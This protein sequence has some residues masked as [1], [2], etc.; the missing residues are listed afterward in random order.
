MYAGTDSGVAAPSAPSL[1]V[2]SCY[3]LPPARWRPN[4]LFV[5]RAP[6]AFLSRL[7]PSTP[8]R[9]AASGVCA[10]RGSQRPARVPRRTVP[11]WLTSQAWLAAAIRRL[12]STPSCA[13]HAVFRSRF[14]AC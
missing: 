3:A 14:P 5:T 9:D 4:E 6:G 1:C 10:P 8:P 2:S 13:R 7:R 11:W 12:D